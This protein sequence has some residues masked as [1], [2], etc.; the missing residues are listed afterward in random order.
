MG[1]A[2]GDGSGGPGVADP[3]TLHVELPFSNDGIGSFTAPLYS[4]SL[5]ELI[6]DEW[7]SD[8]WSEQG[9]A[10]VHLVA[11]SLRALADSIDQ[12]AG[13]WKIAGHFVPLK[14]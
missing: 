3:L 7:G 13:T 5:S 1:G 2:E 10:A 14:D 9:E 8:D 6:D 4:F 11:A 12:R